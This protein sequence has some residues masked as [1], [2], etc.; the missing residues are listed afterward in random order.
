MICTHM[1]MYEPINV[2]KEWHIGN[3]LPPLY[4]NVHSS[5]KKPSIKNTLHFVREEEG[6][7]HHVV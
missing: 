7:E 2:Y 6:L 4:V 3:G 1:G 5:I